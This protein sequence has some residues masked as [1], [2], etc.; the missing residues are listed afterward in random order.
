MS[1]RPFLFVASACLAAALG[2][3]VQAAPLSATDAD[4]LT[5]VA[6]TLE[7]AKLCKL[8]PAEYA[9][10]TKYTRLS[11]AMHLQT[12]GV[13]AADVDKAFSKGRAQAKAQAP[14]TDQKCAATFQDIAKAN[15]AFANINKTLESL[16]AFSADLDK[17]T[18]GK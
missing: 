7:S 16:N 10:L 2:S 14:M 8:A 18:R 4:E 17:A 1:L 15:K 13:S 12:N 5:F 9:E 3:P 6:Q 11:R